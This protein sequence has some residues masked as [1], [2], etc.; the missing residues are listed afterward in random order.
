M[1]RK[2][3]MKPSMKVYDMEPTKIICGS[4]GGGDITYAPGIPADEKQLA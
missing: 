2:K 3:Y 4:G 1:E